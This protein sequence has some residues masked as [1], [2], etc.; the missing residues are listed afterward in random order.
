MT[1]DD[2]AFSTYLA[3]LEAGDRRAAIWHILDLREQGLP[4]DVLALNLI[5]PAQIE[6]GRRW[7]RGEWGVAKEHR[8]TSI[9]EAALAAL[10]AADPDAP[11]ADAPEVAV[12]CVEGEWHALPAKLLGHALAWYGWDVT[13]LGPSMPHA[14]LTRYLEESPPFVLAVSCTVPANL[15]GALAS[16]EAARTAGVPCLAGGRGF[17][18]DD[19]R[20]EW[21]GAAGW[22]ANPTAAADLLQRWV[23]QG[24]P[25]PPRPSADLEALHLLADREDLVAAGMALV[26]ERFP[27]L[28]SYRPD[29]IDR[30]RE[31]LGY[32]IDFV[33]SAQLVADPRVM[34]DFVPWLLQVLSSRG[35]PP[36]ALHLGLDALREAAEGPHPFAAE[37]LASVLDLVPIRSAES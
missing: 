28:R 27:A 12:A 21:L 6:V 10:A 33:A 19:A 7:Q 8:A 36:A 31:D 9:A 16:L 30:T 18:S 26:G 23:E 2:A 35:V 11:A 13:F 37:L 3:H 25:G 20:A 17:G 4:P 1:V 5:A 34:S 14:H 32:I 24:V 29:Q 15:P 22:A